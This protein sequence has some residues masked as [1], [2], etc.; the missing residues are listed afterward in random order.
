MSQLRQYSS[1]FDKIYLQKTYPLLVL[2]PFKL[3]N[4]NVKHFKAIIKLKIYSSATTLNFVTGYNRL[5]VTVK[6]LTT[7]YYCVRELYRGK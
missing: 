6:N 5:T 3:K 1:G 2:V 7:G 4:N